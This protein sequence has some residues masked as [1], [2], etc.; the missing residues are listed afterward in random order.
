MKAKHIT[1]I[2]LIGALIFT[3]PNYAAKNNPVTSMLM[4]NWNKARTWSNSFYI[5]CRDVGVLATLYAAVGIYDFNRITGLNETTLNTYN[6]DEL[7]HAIDRI[8]ILGAHSKWPKKLEEMYM[9]LQGKYVQAM[10]NE[11]AAAEEQK[12]KEEIEQSY[13]ETK[14]AQEVEEMIR[15]QRAAQQKK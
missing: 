4:S 13:D 3:S 9:Q 12:E 11:S 8:K 6:P 2:A 7:Q 15:A 10:H 14:V 5:T 1:T